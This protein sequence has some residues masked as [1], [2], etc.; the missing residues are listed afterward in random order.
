MGTMSKRMREDTVKSEEEKAYDLQEA[1][2][3]LNK[4]ESALRMQIRRGSIQAIKRPFDD[5]GRYKYY[6]P[7][8]E[9]D[10][11][12][13]RLNSAT[14]R[15]DSQSAT[16]AYDAHSVAGNVGSV[17][18]VAPEQVNAYSQRMEQLEDDLRQEREDTRELIRGLQ[19]Q[20]DMMQTMLQTLMKK[21]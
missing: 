20:L 3:L 17:R 8:S 11:E 12:R 6:I 14:N 18:S 4:S 16:T 21:S 5:T 10:K 2:R 15:N 7:E 13:K 19:K 1:A 9:I